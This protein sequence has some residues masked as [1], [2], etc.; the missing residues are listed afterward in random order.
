MFLGTLSST[1]IAS[2]T[3]PVSILGSFIVMRLMHYTVDMFSMMAVTLAVGFVV[4]DAIVM[5]ENIVRHRETGKSKMQAAL[6]GSGEVGFTILSMTISL[7]A[8]FLP[9]LFLNGVL[10]RLHCASCAVYDL[11]FDPGIGHLCVDA[12]THVVQ[13]FS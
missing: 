9:I 1:L 2:A 7:V 12:D 4:D 13:P 6:D 10:G 11:G 5:I 8:V 3:I